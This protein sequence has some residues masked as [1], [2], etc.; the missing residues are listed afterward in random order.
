[1]TRRLATLLALVVASA[2]G[3]QAPAAAPAKAVKT[4]PVPKRPKLAAGADTNDAMAYYQRGSDLLRRSQGEEAERA[5]YWATRIAPSWADPYYGLWAARF[6]NASR[7]RRIDE[8]RAA[9]DSL[10][11]SAAWRNPF[12]YRHFDRTVLDVIVG[13]ELDAESAFQFQNEMNNSH[14]DASYRASLAYDQGRFPEAARLY[15]EAIASDKAHKRSSL[16][17]SRALVFYQMEQ[18]DSA[19]T[20][21]DQFL[22]AERAKDDTAL[23]SGY[24]SKAFVEYQLGTLHSLRGDTAAARA[25]FGRA[26]SEDL[27]FYPAHSALADIA[28]ASHDLP[29]ALAEAEAAVQV[30]EDDA[31]LQYNLGRFHVAVGQADE[32][33]R[34]LK[35]AEAVEPFYA[36]PYY[37]LGRLY[38]QAGMAD[39]ALVQYESFLA[40]AGRGLEEH[41]WVTRRLATLRAA[42]TEAGKAAGL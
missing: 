28:A 33:E 36:M 1:M 19:S 17:Q 9:L 23:T 15:G 6:V 39:E 29:G 7:E 40:H 21:L 35:R 42:P 16:H 31:I 4:A 30:R 24:F 41:G 8:R 38:D 11:E 5:F 10:D 26:L 14:G 20:E 2:A 27:T 22:H 13:R 25:A 3:A 18:Y 12:L 32:A 37:L 34:A